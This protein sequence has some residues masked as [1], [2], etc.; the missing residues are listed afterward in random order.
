[1]ASEQPPFTNHLQGA[2][3]ESWCTK[4]VK[5]DQEYCH[6]TGANSL[7][8]PPNCPSN[9][10]GLS[11]RCPGM[12]RR[13]GECRWHT[14]FGESFQIHARSRN[15][16]VCILFGAVVS[17]GVSV[18]DMNSLVPLIPLTCIVYS[19]PT[20]IC[21]CVILHCVYARLLDVSTDVHLSTTHS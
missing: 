3:P 18:V 2:I 9:W 13:L 20:A 4:D 5:V 10:C 8:L 19:P 12:K 11:Q 16:V 6:I 14:T 1:M 7:C 15:V 17:N 21:L